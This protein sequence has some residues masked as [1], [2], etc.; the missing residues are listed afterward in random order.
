MLKKKSYFTP[1][2]EDSVPCGGFMVLV[3]PFKPII[4]LELIFLLSLVD[5]KTLIFFFLMTLQL[6]QIICLKETFQANLFLD[7]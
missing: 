4:H 1:S 5:I 6:F 2:C 3:Y 7:L